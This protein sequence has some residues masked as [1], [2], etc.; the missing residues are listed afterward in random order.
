MNNR[1]Q[2]VAI[3]M[4]SVASAA[5][6]AAQNANPAHAYTAFKTPSGNIVCSVDTEVICVIKSGQSATAETA[7]QRRRSNHKP[8]QSLGDWTT[9]FGVM[10]RGSRPA[11]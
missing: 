2:C 10:R 3:F 4:L 11:C 5:P 7:L 6:V 8:G 9:G 1:V